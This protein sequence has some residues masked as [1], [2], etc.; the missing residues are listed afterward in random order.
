MWISYNVDN[1]FSFK[2]CKFCYGIVFKEL[3]DFFFV[4]LKYSELV[5]SF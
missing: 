3:C 2:L 5:L 4:V 1:I